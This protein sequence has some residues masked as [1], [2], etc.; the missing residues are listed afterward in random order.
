V[1]IALRPASFQ[2]SLARIVPKP[3][4][5]LSAYAFSVSREQFTGAHD[6]RASAAVVLC[7]RNDEGDVGARCPSMA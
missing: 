4:L 7:P 1:G 3:V 5:A 6:R 2:S